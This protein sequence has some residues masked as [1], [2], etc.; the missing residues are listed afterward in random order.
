MSEAGILPGDVLECYEVQVDAASPPSRRDEGFSGTLLSG[1]ATK[2]P[3]APQTVPDASSSPI[4]TY[5][6]E[7]SDVHPAPSAE[8]PSQVSC[9]ECTLLNDPTNSHCAACD[10]VLP[11]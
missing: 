5:G 9:T 8:E 7:V 1:G 4:L 6:P 10:S 2:P 3:S 11:T